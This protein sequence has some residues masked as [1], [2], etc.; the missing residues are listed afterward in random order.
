MLILCRLE[1]S[2]CSSNAVL[3]HLELSYSR[4][5]ISLPLL[6][7]SWPP[8]SYKNIVKCSILHLFSLLSSR[9]YLCF[10]VAFWCSLGLIV[11][12]FLGCLLASLG[13][14]VLPYGLS[15]NSLGPI[16]GHFGAFLGLS[17]H[18]LC[19]SWPFLGHLWDN[20]CSW[21]PS[22]AHWGSLSS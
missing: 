2:L 9:S 11:W 14:L 6:G 22:V 12:A 7:C 16:L 3:A 19:L 10:L 13:L 21:W 4:L 8:C 20:L 15:W 5:G 17:W 1:P 18:L